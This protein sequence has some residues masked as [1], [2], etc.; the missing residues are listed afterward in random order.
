MAAESPAESL[1]DELS[2]PICLEYFKAPVS[3]HCGHNFCRACISQ[4]WG[5]SQTNFSCPQCRETAQERNFR[6]SRELAR[7]IELARGLNFQAAKGSGGEPVCERHQEALKLF[8]EEDQT[9][10]CVVCDKSKAHRSHTV[11]PIEEAAQEYKEQFQTRLQALMEEREKLMGWKLTGEKRSSEYLGKTEAEREKIVSQFKQLHQFLEKEEQ[12]LL[13][14]LGELEKEIVKLQ[15]ENI[16]KLSVEISRLS[17]LISEMEGKCQQPASEFLQDVRSTLSRC[18]QGK[19]QQPVE[20]SPDLAKQLGDFTQKNIVLKE[21]LKQFQDALIFELQTAINV[22]LDPATAPPWSHLSEVQKSLRWRGRRQLGPSG[23]RFIRSVHSGVRPPNIWG[24][25][26]S[27][28]PCSDNLPLGCT[29][30]VKLTWSHTSAVQGAMAAVQK[31]QDEAMCSICL[32]YFKAPVSI[33]CGHNFCRACINQCWGESEPNFSCPQCRETTQQRNFRPN[34][35]LANMVELVKQ[36]NL[37]A[38]KEPGGQRVCEKHKEPLKLFCEEEQSPICLV[39]DRSKA[40]R[41]HPVI[42]IEE[43]AQ[44]YK[45]QIWTQLQTLKEEREKLLKYRQAEEG[46]SQEYLAKTDAERRKIM[47]EIRQLRQFLE[48]QERL[49]LAQL[50]GLDKEIVKLQNENVTK[51]SAEISRLSELISEME[52][53]CQQPASE[54]LQDIRSIFSRC[55][56][57]KAQAVGESPSKLEERIGDFSEKRIALEMILRK[58]KDTLVFELEVEGSKFLSKEMENIG[59]K[60]N[61]TLDPDTAHPKLILSEDWKHVKYGSAQQDLPHNPKRFDSSLCVLGCEGFTSGRCYW[62]LEVGKEGGWAVGVAKESVK[63]KGPVIYSPEGGICAIALCRGEYCALTSPEE[64][65]LSLSWVLQR[66]WVSLDYE[67]GQVAFFDAVHKSLIFR[68]RMASFTE[69][70]VFPFFW[71]VGKMSWLRL[72]PSET[73]FQS[74]VSNHHFP[75]KGHNHVH[76]APPGILRS[77]KGMSSAEPN[78]AAA[79]A[80]RAAPASGNARPSTFQ[81]GKPKRNTGHPRRRAHHNPARATYLEWGTEPHSAQAATPHP[82]KRD[83]FYSW[84]DFLKRYK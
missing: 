13:A 52:G 44:E 47:S 12:L 78:L 75:Q 55:E 70:R 45:E 29:R 65:P 79:S 14:Q 58:F 15:D 21:T 81:Q 30:E 74:H 10:I 18:E 54:F 49:L 31:L 60:V 22:T 16:T 11:V 43:A 69:E 64:I 19:F 84:P 26:G 76:V 7:V 46:K 83:Y 59:E 77:A 17:E 8:C 20:I 50:G 40:H 25:P 71:V 36:L 3:I 1:R 82:T 37:Q 51:L 61:V 57:G 66:I 6:P 53:K 35:E 34:R 56:K 27:S 80:E 23:I 4:C 33:H 2:C 72:A 9:P 42:P 28:C 32:E 24:T 68:Y 38:G 41:D 67:E 48:E 39:C 73:S 5:E 63:R 62:E